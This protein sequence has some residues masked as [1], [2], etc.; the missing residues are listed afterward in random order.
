MLFVGVLRDWNYECM[1][2]LGEEVEERRTILEFDCNSLILTFH[3]EP[4]MVEEKWSARVALL[5]KEAF[6]DCELSNCAGFVV[7]GE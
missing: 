4:T 1:A 5:R 7:E 6:E 2:L 3:K